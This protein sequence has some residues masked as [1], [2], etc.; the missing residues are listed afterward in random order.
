[1][2]DSRQLYVGLMS[3]TSMDGIDTVLAEFLPQAEQFRLI[4][5]ICT[6][7]PTPLARQIQTLMSPSDNEIDLMGEADVAIGH[8]FALSAN[9]LLERNKISPSDIVAIGSHGQT[10]RH[11]PELD[12]PF[13]LQIGSGHHIA[14]QTG[15]T[16]V[17]D[18]RTKDIA[19][20]GHGAPL[21]PA[22]HQAFFGYES[23]TRVVVNIGGISNITILAPG[24]PVTGFD[25]GPGNALLDLWYQKHQQG[26]FDLNGDW[27]ASGNVDAELL[28]EWLKD[29]YFSSPPPKSTGKEHFNWGW[30]KQ[31][32]P[33]EPHAANVQRSLAEL[34]ASTIS[35]EISAHCPA[36]QA[37]YVCGGGAQ[38]QLLM[39]LLDSMIPCPVR[40][41]STL[42]IDPDWVEA[43]G[44]AWLAKQTLDR[45][46]GNIPEVTG[47]DRA[48]ILGS[49]IYP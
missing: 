10:I 23:H 48:T 13:S 39:Q 27:G 8:V 45:R 36:V 47:A 21:A 28:G 29:P 12:H 3:G 18:F 4:D 44:F 34:T 17:C 31:H 40:S 37:V 6:P 32:L 42:G 16:T 5:S 19:L 11:R 41:S 46:P 49:V 2:K 35:R 30:L 26:S 9:R 33:P 14:A 15:I 43:L 24:K 25:T 20:G 38:N 1:M 22:F 7:Y